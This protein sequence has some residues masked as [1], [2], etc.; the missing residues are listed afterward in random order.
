ME[1][2]DTAVGSSHA[3]SKQEEKKS[4]GS[5]SSHSVRSSRSG[6]EQGRARGPGASR[7]PVSTSP[8]IVGMSTLTDYDLYN[9]LGQGTFGVVTKARQKSSG[10][11]VAI[12]KFIVKD[13]KEGFPITAFR[14]ITIMKKLKNINVLQIVDM[15]HEKD[16]SFF[17]TVSPY[18]SSDLNGLLNNPRIDLSLPQIKSLMQQILQGINYVHQSGYLHRDI[19]TANILLDHFGIVKIADF[20]LAR[21]FH[22]EPP[23][24]ADSPPGGGKF[25]YTGLVVTRWYRPPELLLGDRKYTTAV[26][27]WGIGCVFGELFNKKPI[28]EGRSDVHQA[29]IIFMLLGSPTPENFPNCHLINRHGIDLKNNYPR[30][31]ES[32]FNTF[33][34]P[35]ALKLLA[36]MLTLDPMKRY[37]ALKCLE[38]PFFTNEPL[39]S[40][41]AELSNLEESHESDVKRFKEEVKTLPASATVASAAAPA[42]S[43]AKSFAA[44]VPAQPPTNRVNNS[45]NHSK[46][47][48]DAP[49][50]MN[51]DDSASNLA[52]NFYSESNSNTA[53]NYS[54]H[55]PNDSYSHMEDP[56]YHQYG[57]RLPKR[58]Q[59]H[60]SDNYRGSKR[61]YN[62]GPSGYNNGYRYQNDYMYEEDYYYDR[63]KKFKSRY[64]SEA[65]EKSHPYPN[66]SKEDVFSSLASGKDLYGTGS[67]GDT[68]GLSA[69][70]KVLMKQKQVTAAKSSKGPTDSKASG[71]TD[72]KEKEND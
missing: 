17:Y 8:L 27:M 67:T 33:M 18:I 54:S 56:G 12:K 65:V 69:L 42:V 37:N 5:G 31:L 48:A 55:L 21:L 16:G 29:E 4:S 14:E 15:I 40:D 24:T 64:P 30:T 1:L 23:A 58:H 43:A 20:G 26:D 71:P 13:K 35:D 2:F 52:T 28:L 7:G 22:G 68:T 39:P 6:G 36:G 41:P 57:H 32:S 44:K 66:E 60:Y 38:S 45:L 70:T 72:T 11:L 3:L 47:G 25:E 49:T 9:Q 59:S 53:R 62:Y 34:P 51:R 50:Y 10:K 63:R 61:S 46:Y 19:K